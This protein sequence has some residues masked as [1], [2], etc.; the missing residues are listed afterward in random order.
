MAKNAT[1]MPLK[2]T[3]LIIDDD[4]EFRHLTGELLRQNGWQVLLAGEG[5]EGIELA[6]THRPQAVLCDLL[7]PRCNG[8]L[9]CRALRGNAELRNTRIVIT[10]GRNFAT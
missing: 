4:S 8:F 5:D 7:M 3:V 9:V 1:F 2:K 10:S 6:K